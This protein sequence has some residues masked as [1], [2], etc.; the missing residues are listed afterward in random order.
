MRL[1]IFALIL[2]LL[3]QSCNSK[4]QKRI[5]TDINYDSLRLVLEEMRNQDQEIRRILVDSLAFDSPHAG[6][7]IKQMLDIDKSN[8][9]NIKIILEKYGWL[10]ESKIGK[11]AAEAFFYTV[12]HAD[13]ALIDKYFSDFKRLADV[14]EANPLH[15]AMME[16]RLLMY[17]GKK[18][19]YGTQAADF[20]ADKK[21]AIWPIENPESVNERRAKLG[22][23]TTV[24]QDAKGMDSIYDP[25]EKLPEEK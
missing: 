7:F 13:V 2:F 21:W 8:Q 1:L 9:K 11:T 6:P 15:C 12:Q 10:A 5:T 18:Q 22:F 25:N 4:P 20:R 3:L 16:D 17:K 14:G 19:I 23:K 24:E